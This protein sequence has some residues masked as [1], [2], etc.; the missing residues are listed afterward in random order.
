MQAAPLAAL[1]ALR[2]LPPHGFLCILIGPP[3][4]LPCAGIPAGV[5]PQSHPVSLL[6]EAKP[7]LLSMDRSSHSECKLLM[8]CQGGCC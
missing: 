5:P 2:A 7:K 4:L 1:Q 6:Q 8:L 3:S